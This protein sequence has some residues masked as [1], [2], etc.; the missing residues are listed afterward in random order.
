MKLLSVIY[1]I[2]I[3]SCGIQG[4]KKSCQQDN[5]FCLYLSFLTSMGGGLIRDLFILFVFPSAFTTNCIP[6]IMLALCAGITYRIFL[7]KYETKNVFKQL[8]TLTDALGIGTFIAKGIDKAFALG[9]SQEIALCCGIVTALGGGIL[10]S[11]QRK[12]SIYEVFTTD[13][14]YRIVTIL[15]SILYTCSIYIGVSPITSQY[16]L[17]LYT[18]ILIPITNNSYRIQLI[19]LYI[20]IFRYTKA[21][22]FPVPIPAMIYWQNTCSF[23]ITNHSLFTYFLY[24]PNYTQKRNLY[25]MKYITISTNYK[26]RCPRRLHEV[27]NLTEN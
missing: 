4:S 25:Y 23:Y 9:A 22:I 11:L 12:H 1:Y 8:I 27:D 24:I 26:L 20:N 21:I 15:G 5:M 19:D 16:W 14:T 18:F 6:D 3:I 13:I 10:S 7:Q 2:G 17:I